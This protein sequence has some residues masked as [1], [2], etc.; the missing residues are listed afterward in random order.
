MRFSKQQQVSLRHYGIF[1]DVLQSVLNLPYLKTDNLNKCD[2]I[3]WIQIKVIFRTISKAI[4]NCFHLRIDS[5][6]HIL[7]C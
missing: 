4:Y 6:M 5:Y 1:P 7:L 2:K 3:D